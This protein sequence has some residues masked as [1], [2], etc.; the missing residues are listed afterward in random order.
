MLL[1]M[2]KKKWWKYY[3]KMVQVSRPWIKI[4]EPLRKVIEEGSE[5][6]GGCMR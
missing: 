2:I 3:F 4:T 6:G 1:S 5:R